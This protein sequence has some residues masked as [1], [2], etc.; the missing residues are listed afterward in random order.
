MHAAFGVLSRI[1]WRKM[2]INRA[3][4]EKDKRKGQFSRQD[5][6]KLPKKREHYWGVIARK[7]NTNGHNCVF[8]RAQNSKK[9]SQWIWSCLFFSL[10]CWQHL[11]FLV[12][13]P[14]YNIFRTRCRMGRTTRR[15]ERVIRHLLDTRTLSRWCCRFRIWSS[16]RDG[17]MVT[18]TRSR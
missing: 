10:E 1:E 2:V 8:L 12:E 7:W 11:H 13:L 17:S 4:K 9:I 15:H 6:R 16:A 18:T 3:E 5:K 14:F